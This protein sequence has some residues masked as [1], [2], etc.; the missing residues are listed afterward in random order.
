MKT[1]FPQFKIRVNI[2]I[3]LLCSIFLLSCNKDSLQTKDGDNSIYYWRT[4][5]TLSDAE[6]DFLHKHDITKLYVRFFDVDYDYSADDEEK[7]VPKATIRFIDSVPN[8][9][10]IIPT[11]YITTV[12][13][14]RMQIKED[15]YAEK[16]LKRV[17]AICLHNKIKFNEIQLDCDWTKS[18]R[19]YFFSLCKAIKQQLDSEQCLSSTIRLHQL[20]QTPPPVDKGV[21]MVY[22]TGNLTEMTTD[23]SIFS[24]DDIKPYLRDNRLADYQLPLDVA[25]P[26]YG[27]S[28]V[29]FHGG[30]DIYRF[31]RI[32]R[33][34]D[35]SSYPELKKIGRNTYEATS[36]IDFSGG[37]NYLDRISEKD[38]VRVERPTAKEIMR[39]KGLIDT[40]LKDKKHNNILYHLDEKQFNHY[41][42]NEI[43]EIYTCN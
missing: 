43:S 32:M 29:F 13:M 30:D 25:Y 34:T 42:E 11:I 9:V 28:V 14:G 35:F 31:D 20:T 18:T 22:N 33:R 26:T 12:A 7:I 27:W 36:S 19:K 40:Q 21:L 24:Y 39:V 5:F 16:I 2:V 38:R 37:T 8:G 17:K 3:C 4:T 1:S 41:S 23:N 6:K 15:E 10:E